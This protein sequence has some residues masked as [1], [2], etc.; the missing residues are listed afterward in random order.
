VPA[1]AVIHRT[2]DFPGTY[3]TN[4]WLTL[5]VCGKQPGL[6]DDYNSCG[7]AYMASLIF[8]PLGLPAT[9]PFWSGADTLWT[10]ARVWAGHD[11][12]ASHARD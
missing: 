1:S 6:E 5:G 7:S 11:V 12:K 8:L 9:D 3:D 2:L 4:G 10:Q